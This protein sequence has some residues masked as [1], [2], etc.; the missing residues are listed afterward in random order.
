MACM[1]QHGGSDERLNVKTLKAVL[2]FNLEKRSLRLTLKFQ[3]DLPFPKNHLKKIVY[4]FEVRKK[5]LKA[6]V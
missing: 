5:K 1:Y 2:F 4:H 6:E 3:I